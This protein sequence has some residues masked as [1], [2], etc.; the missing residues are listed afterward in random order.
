MKEKIKRL[1]FKN[2]E[3]VNYIFV[4]GLTT[5]ISLG[6][7]YGLVFTIINPNNAFMLQIANIAS[8]I[9]AVTFAYFTNRIFV[10][11][12][13]NKDVLKEGIQFYC[14]RLLTLF[15]DMIFMFLFVTLLNFN[16]KICKIIVQILILICNYII[17][18]F[19]VFNKKRSKI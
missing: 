17:S 12:S 16:D 10:F 13:N 3:I 19:I 9:S 4:G 2:Q 8:W 11:K 1:Y 7:Y 6:V 14:S 5:V 18:K 15:L